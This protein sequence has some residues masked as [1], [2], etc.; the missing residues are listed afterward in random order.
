MALAT[1]IDVNYLIDVVEMKESKE[2]KLRRKRKQD[3][4][5]VV[6]NEMYTNGQNST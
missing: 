2:W 4:G 3:G 6:G 1:T 5:N